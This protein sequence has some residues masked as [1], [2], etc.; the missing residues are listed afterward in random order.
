MRIVSVRTLIRSLG[1]VLLV[2]SSS[3]WTITIYF[4]IR[5]EGSFEAWNV[6]FASLVSS[7]GTILTLSRV[8]SASNLP[9]DEYVAAI[10]T[11]TAQRQ[12]DTMLEKV[13]AIWVKDWLRNSL[14]A[15]IYMELGLTETPEEIDDPWEFVVQEKGR[16]RTVVRVDNNKLIEYYDDASGALL[17]LGE[18]GSGKTTLLL[19]LLEHLIQRAQEE[20]SL[21]IPVYLNLAAWSSPSSFK[22][23]LIAELGQKYDV[24][25]QLAT[26]WIDTGEVQ[27]L[28]DGFDEIRSQ[29][30]REKCASAINTFR[31]H[32]GLKVP[33]L[34]VCSRISEY[35]Q[36]R[37]KLRVRHALEL[38]RPS[39]DQILSYLSKVERRG[40]N[41]DRLR[42][43]INRDSSGYLISSP[44]I[45]NI[46]IMAFSNLPEEAQIASTR[47]QNSWPELFELY[48]NRMLE[49]RTQY[50]TFF[51]ETDVKAW[52]QWLAIKMI[53]H[54]PSLLHVEHMQPHWIDDE[55]VRYRYRHVF[56]LST[57]FF[58]LTPSYLV[59]W[60]ATDYAG[61]IEALLLS[62]VWSIFILLSRGERALPYGRIQV[63]EA[64]GW[65]WRDASIGVVSG[66]VIG[67]L[68]LGA[69]A[70]LSGV[71]S[72][73]LGHLV[74]Y[75]IP[76]MLSAAYISGV[77]KRELETKLVPMQGIIRSFRNGLLGGIIWG[78][79]TVVV[80]ALL[81]Q[82]Q[83]FSW[84]ASLVFI[85]GGTIVGFMY[86]GGLTCFQHFALRYVLWRTNRL[87]LRLVSF[88]DYA[89]ERV[90]LRKVGGGYKFVHRALMEH[91]ATLN[92]ERLS[93]QAAEAQ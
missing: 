9:I 55:R 14:H 28:L 58:F 24:P 20:S 86:S 8:S 62:T 53:T 38:Q 46:A 31:K 23:W 32:Y 18:P 91:F 80:F 60:I 37:A 1:Y 69:R 82:L 41:L 22:E 64:L 49:R 93:K 75:T 88:L 42:Q 7:A 16:Q 30:E 21:A 57:Y 4:W 35:K 67:I 12:R 87:P 71:D 83:L 25:E 73:T 44:L 89:S 74:G 70:L 40:G 47:K 79:G 6:L 15:A 39:S 85:I 81:E 26:R 56:I 61:P 45:L 48:V 90:F 11:R 59:L 66:L 13:Q 19:R 2:S 27:P 17:I 36:L 78:T 72:I 10:E 52:L 68:A 33:K 54:S 51:N 50:R 76:A 77:Q 29:E 63:A 84:D 43:E 5:T 3:F 92:D 65:S 34:V